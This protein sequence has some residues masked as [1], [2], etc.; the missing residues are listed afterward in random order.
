VVSRVGQFSTRALSASYDNT[1][2][3]EELR[4]VSGHS[5]RDCGGRLGI[6]CAC[7]RHESG[8]FVIECN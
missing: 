2:S 1:S 6:E 7:L 4:T 5:T 3:S 8:R